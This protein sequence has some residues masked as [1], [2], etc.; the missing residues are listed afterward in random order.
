[1]SSA[2]E[3]ELEH[4]I[5]QLIADARTTNS[6]ALAGLSIVI[7]EH[8]A[9]FP[10]EFNMMWKSRLSL[11]NAFY[12]WIRYFT[13]LALL[14]DVSF[15]LRTE[16]SDHMSFMVVDIAASCQ[17]FFFAEMATSTIITVSADM[18]LILRV[19]ILYGRSKKLLYFFVALITAEIIAMLT[20]G[21]Y[22]IKPLVQY[23][24][25]G[26]NVGGCYSLGYIL[27]PDVSDHIT[28]SG[29]TEVPRLFTYFN[30]PVFIVA[31]TMFSMTL[32]KCGSTLVALGLGRTP[33]IAL[34][35]R[36]G[37]FWF[38]S[39]LVLSLVEIIIW[40]RARPTLAQIPVV[41]A[42]ACVAVIGA[43]V[44]LNIKQLASKPSISATITTTEMHSMPVGHTNK[45]T[46]V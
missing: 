43:R 28:K 23:V 8:L 42:T 37:V 2:T 17:R 5:F 45:R 26:S 24:H 30:V 38:L 25:I 19:W 13:L 27:C 20:V 46:I 7:Y 15:M 34:F 36:D 41:P 31:V 6:L 40:A 33:M 10:D 11:S 4:E 21:I 16:W 1:M 29:S 12:F 9:N 22:T 32:Y 35:M 39:L 3:Q 18:I 44:V 14:V